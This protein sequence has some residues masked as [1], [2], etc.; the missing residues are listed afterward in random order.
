MTTDDVDPRLRAA[1]D[2]VLDPELR[3][4]VTELGMIPSATLE[5]GAARVSVLLTVSGCPLRSTIE[6]DLTAA[7]REVP[8]VT[9]VTIDVG[10]MTPA[11]RQE[12][13]ERLG[14][15]R[16]NPFADPHTLTRVHAVTSGKGGVG[17]SS[18]TVNLAAAL[19][20]M[21]RT[22]GIVD[23][24]IHGF[25]VPG[26]LGI[27]Q[28]PTRV[29]DMI[30]PPVVE[31]PEGVDRRPEDSAAGAGH[32]SRGV[33]KVISIGMFVDPS[34]PVAW[35]GPMLH[36]AVEQ[37]LTDVHFGD[38]DHLLLDLP[39]GTGDIAISV[40]QLLPRSGVVVVSTPQHAAVSV[41]QRSGTLAEQTEQR[42]TGV[43]ENM[44]AMVM[45]DGTR[46]EVFG[47]GGGETIARSLT[48]R[49]GY[50][51]P[52]LGSVPLDVTV[53][54][55]SDRGVP[56]VWANPDSPAATAMWDVARALD[57][58]GRGLAGKSLGITPRG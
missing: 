32:R 15:H 56:A 55:A 10:V 6:A 51:V 29:G 1:L 5:D 26:L 14:H 45:P 3:R 18:V 4:P 52:L 49:L 7:L 42:V 57:E 58:Q 46:M 28:A 33:I 16:S 2:G 8:E 41:A 43:V 24:D 39:P 13:Q 31:V 40:G 21:G 9:D 35:R 20:A 23:A 27:T 25:S 44:S 11:Q 54:E 37:F 22:V 38:L 47:S 48:E 30:L 19:A 36:R 17:K 53:R 12:L 34:Q 50:D